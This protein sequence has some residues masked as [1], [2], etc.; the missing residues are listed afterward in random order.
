MLEAPTVKLSASDVEAFQ[1]AL[2]A[3]NPDLIPE[4]QPRWVFLEW[5][6]QQGYL[7]HG[8]PTG[9]LSKLNPTPKNYAQPDD[10]SNTVGVYA[11]SD[12]LWPMMY[13]LRGPQVTAQNDM[14]LKLMEGGEWSAMKYFLSYGTSNPEISDGRELMAPGFVYVMTRKG[15]Q[16]SPP[17]QHAGL[18]YVQEAHWVNLDSVQPL[19]CVPVAPKDFPLPVRVHDA[20][21]LRAR[22]RLDPRGFPW[23]CENE[24]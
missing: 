9:D 5:L 6:A 2:D 21:A 18:G 12:G 24:A 19:M 1:A 7:L 22:A 4:N 16:L 15:F 3:R 23:L 17:Y 10:F 8:S 11:T 14:G 13:A 20:E